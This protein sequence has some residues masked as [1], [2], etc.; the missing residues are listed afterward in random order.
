MGKQ[1]LYRQCASSFTFKEDNAVT[2]LVP[3][4]G[5]LSPTSTVLTPP[6]PTMVTPTSSWSASTCTTT[7]PPAAATCPV[8]SLWTSSPVPWT[9]CVLAHSVSSSAQT[10]L[11]SARPVLVTIGP[12]VTTP[13]V[14]S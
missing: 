2:K 7:R 9:P 11:C 6:V 4:S 1:S 3:S 5:R 10:T 8:P 13:R 14:L 12:R